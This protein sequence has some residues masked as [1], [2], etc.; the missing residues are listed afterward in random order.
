MT[1]TH[2]VSECLEVATLIVPG[3]GAPFVPNNSTSR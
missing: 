2:T 1:F 3:H